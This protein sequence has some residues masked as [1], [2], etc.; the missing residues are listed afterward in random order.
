M[1]KRLTESETVRAMAK[2]LAN[3]NLPTIPADIHTIFEHLRSDLIH[4]YYRW[5]VFRQLFAKSK[6]RVE[7][8]GP[9][10]RFFGEVEYML[11]DSVFLHICRMTDPPTMGRGKH[12]QA[13]IGQLRRALDGIDQQAFPEIVT[14]IADL[15]K[16]LADID[17]KTQLI[18]DHRNKRISHLDKPTFL[19]TSP[20]NGVTLTMVDEALGE[21]GDFINAFSGVVLNYESNFRATSGVGDGDAVIELLKKV[22]AFNELVAEDIAVADRVSKGPYADA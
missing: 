9:A 10:S 21:I 4:A 22:F 3:H 15:D 6:E 8:M 17:T 1:A 19:N 5:L 2:I 7:L 12:E 20:L 11:I 16:R 14:L 18:R 13:V